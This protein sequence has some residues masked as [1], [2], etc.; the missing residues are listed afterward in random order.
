MNRTPR[1]A[2]A[3]AGAAALVALTAAPSGAADASSYV[4]LGDSYSSG[5]GT[6]SYIA[7]GTDCRRSTLAYPSL[8]AAARGYA[9]D[10]RACSGATVPDVTTAQLGALSASTDYVTLSVGGNDAGFADVLTECAM[11]SWAS[12]CNRAIDGAQSYISSTLPGRLSTLYSQIR[13]R[14]PQAKVVIV[15]YPRIFMGE[16]SNA[17]TW[18]S[19]SEQTRLNQTADQ[20]NALLAN[21]ASAAGFTF[22]NPTTRFTGH[23]VCDS[24]EWING[25]SYPIDESYHPNRPGHA[26]GYTPLV[27]APLSG[28]TVRVTTAITT[29]AQESGPAQATLQRKRAALDKTIKP[30]E[31]R[32]PDLSSPKVKA[33]AKALGIDVSNRAEVDRMDRVHSAKQAKQ[34]KAKA[35]QE[36]GAAAHR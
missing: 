6:R 20:L 34:A 13:S 19:P 18:F 5:L 4:A 26:N 23:A 10:L 1:R 30:K 11:P 35:K 33:K 28:S 12:R 32:R 9:L 3:L 29:A 31:V 17:F 24:P 27:S 22:V 2:A 8:V 21:R 15:G 25:L 36:K 7:D 16:D 14:A